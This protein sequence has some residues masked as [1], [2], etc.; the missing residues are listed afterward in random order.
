[1]YSISCYIGKDINELARTRPQLKHDLWVSL[2]SIPARGDLI[3][4]LNE[5]YRVLEVLHVSGGMGPPILLV[6]RFE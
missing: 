4:H 1:M 2:T 5:M 6:E 3:A